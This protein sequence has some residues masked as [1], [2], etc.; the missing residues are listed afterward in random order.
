MHLASLTY[1]SALRN[2]DATVRHQFLVEAKR[3]ILALSASEAK[4]HIEGELKHHGG[5]LVKRCGGSGVWKLL[6][7][8]NALNFSLH[9]SFL[10]TEWI[11]ENPKDLLQL[12]LTHEVLHQAMR[13]AGLLHDVAHLPFS[14]LTE[15]ALE[16]LYDW[17]P[18]VRSKK[19]SMFRKM[20]GEHM[21]RGSSQKLHESLRDDVIVKE[22]FRQSAEK[23]GPPERSGFS[24]IK[25]FALILQMFLVERIFCGD[26]P[27]FSSLKRLIDGPMDVDRLDFSVRD[28]RYSGLDHGVPDHRRVCLTFHLHN[29]GHYAFVPSL[30]AIHDIERVLLARYDFYK[31][32]VCHHKVVLMDSL[33]QRCLELAL[34]SD[35]RKKSKVED[36]VEIKDDLLQL[37]LLTQND[38]QYRDVALAQMDDNWLLSIIRSRFFAAY[39]VARGGESNKATGETTSFNTL[40][41]HFFFYGSHL[42]SLWKRSSDMADLVASSAL[43]TDCN[44]MDQFL[45]DCVETLARTAREEQCGRKRAYFQGRSDLLARCMHDFS[46]VRP[47]TFATVQRAAWLLVYEGEAAHLRKIEERVSGFLAVDNGGPRGECIIAPTDKKL[48]TGFSDTKPLIVYDP[49]GDRTR[50]FSDVSLL[51]HHLLQD[52]RAFPFF[53]VYIPRQSLKSSNEICSLVV[54]E[55]FVEVK[56]LVEKWEEVK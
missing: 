4:R 35:I 38:G 2:A 29:D 11:N 16:N 14:H 40:A 9:S 6:E 27:L 17:L 34:H 22:V 52:R 1:G 26:G 44:E 46:S 3:V 50:K 37:I 19:A 13:L 21:S 39:S 49:F 28:G 8:L 30:Q 45:A 36:R 51:E 15:F 20:I 12:S 43:E 48:T 25:Y 47:T 53:F 56:C 31:Y 41:N 54:K 7:P 10:A 18:S 5:S 24:E 42:R 33:L 32:V 23:L 55:L